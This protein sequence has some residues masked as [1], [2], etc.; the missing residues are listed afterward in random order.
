MKNRILITLVFSLSF[1]WAQSQE[2]L[3]PLNGNPVLRALHIQ[4]GIEV[5]RDNPEIYLG[6]PFIDDFSKPGPY[7]D[8]AKWVD[9]FAFVNTS[10]APYPPTVG[11]ATLDILDAAGSVYEKASIS[12][13]RADHLTSHFIRLDSLFGSAPR[14]LSPADSIYFSFWYQPQG[15]GNSPEPGDV[16]LLQ[17]LEAYRVDTII[18]TTASPPD[19]LYIDQWNTVWSAEGQTLESFIAQHGDYFAQV[20]IPVIDPIYFIKDF[21]FRFVNYGSMADHSLPSWQSNVDH[22]NIDYV[23]L[24]MNRSA[25]K[26]QIQDITF[27]NTPSSLLKRYDAMPYSQFSVDPL[28][29]MIDSLRPLISNLGVD[30]PITRYYYRIQDEIGDTLF[31]YDGGAFNLYPYY[32][33]G[34]QDYA[35]HAKPPFSYVLPGGAKDSTHFSM[36]WILEKAGLAGDLIKSN[37]TVRYVQKFGN[38]LAYDD[39]TAEAGYGL[40]PAGAKLAYRFVLDH[41]DTLTA[42]QMFFNQTAV[43]A[44]QQF[45]FLTIW[46][47]AKN[48]PGEVL[49]KKENV[50]PV[51]SDELNGFA[52]YLIDSESPLIILDTFFVGW[53]Q[54]TDDN[55]NVGYDRHRNAQQDIYYSLNNGPWQN[56]SFSGCLMIR[57][58]FGKRIPPSGKDILNPGRPQL[59]LFPNPARAGEVL[60]LDLMD[61]DAAKDPKALVRIFDASGRMVLDMPFE[62]QME[63]PPLRAGVYVIQVLSDKLYAPAV[64]R[65]I[66]SQ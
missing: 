22:W 65:L 48:K 15:F 61:Q 24:D 4:K 52:S 7:P 62:N 42:I 11:V 23:H 17:F 53:V 3:V 31:E 18:D 16:L 54:T 55:L 29:H 57:P 36:T 46:K 35:P 9:N 1:F 56:S 13:F 64:N 21:R 66:I 32:L 50:M 25:S 47:N 34:Y 6:L 2:Y 19:T 59:G 40:T 51:Y 20:M 45:F 28:K 49:W 33:S 5:K 27:V 38:Y 14:P 26:P 10:Y 8:P 37:D 44:N 30:T 41:P 60:K 39:G 63:V 43:S 12:S 58:V